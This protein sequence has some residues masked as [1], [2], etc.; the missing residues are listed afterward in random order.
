MSTTQ[1]PCIHSP[2]TLLR[3]PVSSARF[4]RQFYMNF[5]RSAWAH[6]SSTLCLIVV[7]THFSARTCFCS[8]DASPPSFI[9][10]IICL[11]AHRSNSQPTCPSSH[12]H[13]IHHLTNT[14]AHPF[15]HSPIGP[16]ISWGTQDCPHGYK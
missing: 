10:L 3:S 12:N 5:T 14:S 9:C 13:W 8:N 6:A 7:P 15:H 11:N 4:D 16:P 1:S 2:S